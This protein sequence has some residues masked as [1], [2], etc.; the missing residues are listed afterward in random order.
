MGTV[1]LS[2]LSLSLGNGSG[3]LGCQACIQ[4]N[5][6]STPSYVASLILEWV[7]VSVCNQSARSTQPGHP[8]GYAQLSYRLHGEGLEWL[9]VVWYTAL[10]VYLEYGQ[11]SDV[12]WHLTLENMQNDNAS[13]CAVTSFV[14][15][16][17]SSFSISSI[18]V[19]T[20]CCQSSLPETSNLHHTKHNVLF[21]M[22]MML[23]VCWV[24]F[25]DFL[26]LLVRVALNIYACHCKISLT[27]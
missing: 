15:S 17:S 14:E 21:M 16:S 23:R 5:A 11:P 13:V 24:E 9:I 20:I 3:Q 2:V 6:T 10:C 22:P 8:P 26:I 18:Q 7:N 19:V 4:Q 12:P 25:C 27:F 1:K